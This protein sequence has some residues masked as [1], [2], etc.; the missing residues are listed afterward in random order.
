L[1]RVQVKGRRR[2]IGLG[3]ITDATLAEAREKAA[4][5]RKVARAGGD[6]IDVRTSRP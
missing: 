2:D 1:L 6:P 4:T 5:L 3:S